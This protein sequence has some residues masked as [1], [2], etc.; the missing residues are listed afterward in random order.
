MLKPISQ[1]LSTPDTAAVRF[2]WQDL[3][4]VGGISIVAG[5]PKMG[6]STFIRNLIA[7]TVA[8][9]SSD[10]KH[11]FLDIPIAEGP[12]IYLALE[13]DENE[14]RR[15]LRM[16]N[17]TAD[18]PLFVDCGGHLFASDKE[19][20]AWLN[21]QIEAVKAILCVIDPLFRFLKPR[22]ITNY[23][24]VTQMIEPLLAVARKQRCHILTAHHT[25]K[26]SRASRIDPM[27]S[28]LGSVAI[29]GA[30]DTAFVIEAAGDPTPDFAPYRKITA[31][32]KYGRGFPWRPTRWWPRP[33]ANEFIYRY[34][35]DGD[36]DDRIVAGNDSYWRLWDQ[37]Q[38]PNQN[39]ELIDRIERL[40]ANAFRLTAHCAKET[41]RDLQ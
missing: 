8:P 33:W 35:G 25:T 34:I 17:V 38:N 3:L 1:L 6:K 41:I 19:A 40:T 39:Q 14:V 16:L 21:E 27:A 37:G 5:Q 28:I 11:A 22:A 30:V 4:P 31:K 36:G 23:A 15:R 9:T 2:F 7:A 24:A 29:F 13:D 20:I 26:A 12:A 32:L 18:A 10:G